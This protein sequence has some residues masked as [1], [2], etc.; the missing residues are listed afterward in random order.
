MP[1][2]RKTVIKQEDEDDEAV[3]PTAGRP[4]RAARLNHRFLGTP[5]KSPESDGESQHSLVVSSHK[6]RRK[7]E[8][9]VAIGDLLDDVQ[10]AVKD[11]KHVESEIRIAPESEVPA[12]MEGMVMEEEDVTGETEE[13]DPSEEIICI[14]CPPMNAHSTP[15]ILE[16]PQL[17]RKVMLKAQGSND[18]VSTSDLQETLKVFSSIQANLSQSSVSALLQRDPDWVRAITQKAEVKIEGNTLAGS[19]ESFSAAAVRIQQLLA[20]EMSCIQTDGGSDNITDVEEATDDKVKLMIVEGGPAVCPFCQESFPS[21]SLKREHVWKDHEPLEEI[22]T[23][24]VFGSIYWEDVLQVVSSG[25]EE[26]ER[27]TLCDFKGTDFLAHFKEKHGDAPLSCRYC[28]VPFEDKKR[29]RLHVLAHLEAS[30]LVRCKYCDREG[31][32]QSMKRH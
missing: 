2:K 15:F 11:D 5:K 23:V 32:V 18:P 3:T 4:V 28:R 9:T 16:L 21:A 8:A 31:G 20:A 24:P 14:E 22:V 1:R 30:T 6:K 27:C 26:P 12:A 19:S 10:A 17:T 7:K 29:L 13:G 25:K